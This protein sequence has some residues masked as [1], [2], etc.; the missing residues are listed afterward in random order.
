MIAAWAYGRSA[1]SLV[2]PYA[3]HRA[4]EAMPW[5]YMLA[6][7]RPAVAPAGAHARMRNPSPSATVFMYRRSSP[8]SFDGLWVSPAARNGRSAR[9][10]A[11]ARSSLL[12]WSNSHPPSFFCCRASHAS[13]SPTARSLS[14]LPPPT[15]TSRDRVEALRPA[16]SAL[17]VPC[18]PPSPAVKLPASPVAPDVVKSVAPNPG[19]G[20]ACVSVVVTSG[21]PTLSWV[22]MPSTV[23][24]SMRSI[25]GSAASIFGSN[26]RS[27]LVRGWSSGSSLLSAVVT[28]TA[29]VGFVTAARSPMTRMARAITATW[30]APLTTHAGT[31]FLMSRSC[32]VSSA[33]SRRRITASFGGLPL[34]LGALGLFSLTVVPS[35]SA[36]HRR[37]AG[38]AGSVGVETRVRSARTRSRARAPAY[39]ARSSGASGGWANGLRVRTAAISAFAFRSPRR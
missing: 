26:P 8:L 33:A 32:A 16:I 39:A 14:S 29:S 10:V 27:S 37:G 24:L 35:G 1:G 6:L 20:I 28:M 4:I 3:S 22:T 25:S 5:A 36:P 30:A 2:M 11:A 21:R 34:A 7:M 18:R 17:S 15:R 38:A 13:P 12:P 19:G 9:P 23:A 31:C